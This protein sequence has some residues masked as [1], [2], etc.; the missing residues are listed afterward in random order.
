ALPRAA[1]AAAGTLVTRSRSPC[2]I[3][4]PRDSLP[5]R[6]MMLPALTAVPPSR[7][8]NGRQ[9]SAAATRRSSGAP[10]RNIMPSDD[11]AHSAEYKRSP[12]SAPL[13][14]ALAS[15]L[16]DSAHGRNHGP[17]SQLWTIV[18]R[19]TCSGDDRAASSA[20]AAASTWRAS[21]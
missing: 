1:P 5:V 7:D 4:S 13:M 20:S 16:A 17:A 9:R 14:I 11:D 19:A 6:L 15:L 8:R 2:S 10:R 21:A 12:A 3:G 18:V